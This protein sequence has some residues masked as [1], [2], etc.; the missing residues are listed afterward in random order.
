M[1][2]ALVIQANVFKELNKSCF[3]SVMT[4]TESRGAD[5]SVLFKRS[6]ART[7][8]RSALL[9]FAKKL[10]GKRRNESIVPCAGG[11]PTRLTQGLTMTSSSQLWTIAEP[12]PKA[13]DG[14]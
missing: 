3:Q 5:V 11:K 9:P 4:S 8:P 10:P 13:I 7:R 12:G 1:S 6:V 2:K 14:K